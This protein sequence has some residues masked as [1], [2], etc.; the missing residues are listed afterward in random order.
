MTD[1]EEVYDE[2]SLTAT[3]WQMIEVVE[4]MLDKGFLMVDICEAWNCDTEHID[5]MLF[6]AYEER[7]KLLEDLS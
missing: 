4:R 1:D 6:R 7:A 3:G 5:Y 2:W